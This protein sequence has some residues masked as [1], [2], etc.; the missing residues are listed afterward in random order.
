MV[1]KNLGVFGV[2]IVLALAALIM[3]FQRDS[4]S[5]VEMAVV[6]E[7]AIS[8]SF[9]ASGSMIYKDQAELSPEII[10]TVVDVLIEEGDRVTRGD[11]LLRIDDRTLRAELEQRRALVDIEQLNVRQGEV[12]TNLAK[13]QYDRVAALAE[14][15]FATRAALDSAEAAL[16]NA[17]LTRDASAERMRQAAAALT[18]AR[19]Q[20]SRTAIRAPVSGTVIA[21]NIEVGETA[22][23]SSIGI[24]GSPLVVI[25]NTDTLIAEIEVG[26]A[27]IARVEPGRE[28]SLKVAAYPNRSFAGRITFV[29]L[30]PRSD[31]R[32]IATSAS[33]NARTYTIEA[34]L[35]GEGRELLRP[36]MS[37][38]AEIS[39]SASTKTIA[40][41]LQ[42][43][44]YEEKEVGGG[45]GSGQKVAAT[46]TPYVFV[47]EDGKAVRRNVTL[48][49]SDDTHRE[50]LSG[51]EKGERVVT[52]PYRELRF[53]KDGDALEDAGEASGAQAG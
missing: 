42:A 28:V 9:T 53:M 16:N 50:I 18:Q 2:L 41:P 17:R 33:N 48:G 44:L 37:C 11:I 51:V 32:V 52:G 30:S 45:E 20:L 21:V 23:P 19:D 15:G 34:E 43:I 36:G 14:R 8:P 24:A 35:T 6:E 39:T 47:F 7:R 31:A 46:R 5:A 10:G 29:A 3:V 25:A 26:E 27:D 40:V 12:S 1:R 13:E 38:R 49:I 4:A 22:V